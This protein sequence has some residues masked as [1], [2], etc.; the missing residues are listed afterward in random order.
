MKNDECLEETRRADPPR[1]VFPGAVVGVQKE[2]GDDVAGCESDWDLPVQKI[3]VE[4]GINAER[5]PQ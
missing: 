3:I 2:D 4:L 5:A 1:L